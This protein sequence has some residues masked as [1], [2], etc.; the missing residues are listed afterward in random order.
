MK[1]IK[2]AALL[3]IVGVSLVGVTEGVLWVFFP[4]DTNPGYVVDIVFEE[5]EWKEDL[6]IK[7]EVRFVVNSGGFRPSP[8]EGKGLK[9]RKPTVLCLGGAAGSMFQSAEHTFWGIIDKKLAEESAGGMS[10]VAGLSG[11]A[12]IMN[13]YAWCEESLARIDPSVLVIIAGVADVLN[14]GPWYI[15]D[16]EKAFRIRAGVTGKRS[17]KE[18]L[19]KVSQL[20]RMARRNRRSSLVHERVGALEKPNTLLLALR[21]SQEVYRTFPFSAGFARTE[22]H[23]PIN[24]YLAGIRAFAY[25]AHQRGIKL[26]VIGEASL[27]TQMILPSELQ[28]LRW[29]TLVSDKRWVRLDPG[30]VERELARYYG[31]AAEVC[32]ELG[33]AFFNL[34]AVMPR[35]TEYYLDETRFTDLGNAKAAEKLYP[36]IKAAVLPDA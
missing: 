25:L 20:A 4:Q 16:E 31:K 1:F 9:T 3:G 23:D 30:F 13:D 5:P 27:H 19:M 34:N 7:K 10:V 36:I 35:G 18:K 15:Y 28:I 17:A 32:G 24:E 33:V 22:S 29:P 14:R 8:R 12:G 6:G 26:V 2:L 21:Q 11:N